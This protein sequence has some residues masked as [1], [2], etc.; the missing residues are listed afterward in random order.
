MYLVSNT[1]ENW[2]V[3]LLQIRI[4]YAI[5]QAKIALLT[6]GVFRLSLMAILT[7][8]PSTKLHKYMC[9]KD[10]PCKMFHI[11]VNLLVCVRNCIF[12]CSIQYVTS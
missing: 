11:L 8:P 1:E 7:S 9:M 2:I 3:L 10:L 12:T 4:T 6:K 5:V